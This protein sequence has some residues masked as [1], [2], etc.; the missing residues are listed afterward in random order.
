M[1]FNGP[2]PEISER[3]RSAPESFIVVFLLQPNGAYLAVDMSRVEH[4]NIGAI[5]P[6]RAY[7][8]VQTAPVEWLVRPAGDP[9][10]QFWL[11]THAWDP[12]GLRYAGREP[13]IITREGRP[14]WR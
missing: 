2:K 14:L 7:R 3:R 6:D 4:V 12:S 8:E 1:S 9:D 10:V 5:G 11:Q 13:L